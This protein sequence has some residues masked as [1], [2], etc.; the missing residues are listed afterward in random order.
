MV[1]GITVSWERNEGSDLTCEPVA[2]ASVDGFL[3]GSARGSGR[4]RIGR[5]EEWIGLAF[6]AGVGLLALPFVHD[7]LIVQRIWLTLCSAAGLTQ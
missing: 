5:R 3:P 7:A 4:A 2:P 1:P 6:F